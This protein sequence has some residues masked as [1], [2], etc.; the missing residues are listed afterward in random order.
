MYVSNLQL[1]RHYRELIKNDDRS[2]KRLIASDAGYQFFYSIDRER[3][4]KSKGSIPRININGIWRT[5]CNLHF[6]L[7]D[8]Q[9]STWAA[10]VSVASFPQLCGVP[11]VGAW[12][13]PGRSRS[14]PPSA[15]P[16]LVAPACHSPSRI[17]CLV[18]SDLSS[19]KPSPGGSLARKIVMSITFTARRAFP[20]VSQS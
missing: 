15:T 13:T 4:E 10:G 6:W 16:Q 11:E 9:P 17:I 8:D 18:V 1:G 3:S 14:R 5:W 12:T 2:H 19:S 7:V 20:S